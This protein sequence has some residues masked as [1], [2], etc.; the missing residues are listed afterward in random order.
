MEDT[1]P[2]QYLRP[3]RISADAFLPSQ[4]CNGTDILNWHF[5][6]RGDIIMFQVLVR[7]TNSDS[8]SWNQYE[9]YN[10]KQIV[11]IPFCTML[12]IQD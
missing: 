8:D 3:R 5:C 11:C 10:P 2:P 12:L 9:V 1:V 4:C 6:I 7:T